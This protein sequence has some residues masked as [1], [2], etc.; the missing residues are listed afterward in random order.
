[1]TNDQIPSCLQDLLVPNY[2]TRTLGSQGDVLLVVPGVSK[3]RQRGSYQAAL[4][5]SLL[6]LQ[7]ADTLSTLKIKTFLLDEDY[8]KG[9]F[10]VT[11][12]SF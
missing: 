10:R 11:E 12:V 7:E 4:L 8:T 3:S 2:L 1:V 9:Y 6:P 5:C